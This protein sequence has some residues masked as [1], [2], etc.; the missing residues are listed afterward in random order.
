MG[1]WI[2]TGGLWKSTGA[3]CL[4]F[5]HDRMGTNPAPDT[6][7]TYLNM[8][9][10]W[11]PPPTLQSCNGHASYHSGET[12]TGHTSS[13][14]R[15]NDGSCCNHSSGHDDH[16]GFEEHGASCIHFVGINCTVTTSSRR[17]SE[18]ASSVPDSTHIKLPSSLS[19]LLPSSSPSPAAD[20]RMDLFE[21]RLNNFREAL[22]NLTASYS[23]SPPPPEI[24]DVDVS[25]N[26]ARSSSS[27]D[28][29]WI[30]GVSVGGAVCL[31]M[32]VS[33][34]FLGR[35]S[36]KEACKEAYA[37]SGR[38]SVRRVQMKDATVTS[39][40]VTSTSTDTEIA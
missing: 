22:N 18:G 35:H 36:A 28:E 34:Y 20:T 15:F 19:S 17:H 3:R 27:N 16:C 1:D 10:S 9:N 31:I 21:T 5:G 29:G 12:I 40:T 30:I 38:P 13:Y 33:A 23:S 39:A 11:Q 14:T 32:I 6:M 4:V 37:A 7:S 25:A 8:I 2:K 26:T 24:V